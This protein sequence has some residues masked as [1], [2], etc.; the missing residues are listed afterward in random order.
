MTQ[1]LERT[2]TEAATPLG[3]VAP[4]PNNDEWLEDGRAGDAPP[5]LSRLANL[6]RRGDPACLEAILGRRHAAFDAGRRSLRARELLGGREPPAPVDSRLEGMTHFDEELDESQRDA[7]ARALAA[8]DLCLIQGLPGTGKTRVLSEIAAQWARRDGRV[9]VVAPR[10]G[11]LAPILNPLTLRD[12]VFAVWL[13]APGEVG[14]APLP[15]LTDAEQHRRFEQQLRQRCEQALAEAEDRYRQAERDL[16]LLPP[17]EEAAV[18]WQKAAQERQDLQARRQA[19]AEQVRGE[20]DKPPANDGDFLKAVRGERARHDEC[21]RTL[22]QQLQEAAKQLEQVRAEQVQRLQRVERQR[23]LMEAR[24]TGRWFTLAWWRAVLQGRRANDRLLELQRLEA[25]ALQARLVAE[26]HA[27]ELQAQR[28][29]EA[30][31]HAR[32]LA[33]LL[34]TETARRQQAVDRELERVATTA[35]QHLQVWRQHYSALA[36]PDS[37]DELPEAQRVAGLRK[38]LELQFQRAHEQRELARRRQAWQLALPSRLPAELPKLANVVA[39]S[40]RAWRVNPA[41]AGKFDVVLVDN[42]DALSEQDLACLVEHADRAVL[43]GRPPVGASS[44]PFHRLWQ[45]L[46]CDPRTLPHQWEQSGDS[47]VCRLHAVADS[48]TEHVEVEHLV[49]EPDVQLRI[50]SRPGGR[51]VLA[52][53]AFPLARFGIHEAKAFLYRNL[54]ELPLRPGT[55]WLRW[56]ENGEWLLADFTPPSGRAEEEMEVSLE[57][58]VSEVVHSAAVN[59]RKPPAAC[60]MTARLQFDRRLGWDLTRAQQWL[61]DRTGL[62]DLGRTCWLQY[63]WRARP[64]L[65]GFWHEHLYAAAPIMGT[66]GTAIS[67]GSPSRAGEACVRFVCVGGTEGKRHPPPSRGGGARP[68][69]RHGLEL[70]LS[71]PRQRQQLPADLRGALPTHGFVN[72]AEGRTLLEQLR[73]LLNEPTGRADRNVYPTVAVVSWQASQVELLRLLWERECRPAETAAGTPVCFCPVE[74]LAD[75]A[76][77]QPEVVC[78]SLCRSHAQRPL[79]Y[80]ECVDEWVALLT[81]AAQRLILVGD[82]DSLERRSQCL[83]PLGKQDQATADFER[84]LT[85]ALLCLARSDATDKNVHPT[86]KNAAR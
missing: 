23:R 77:G 68:N 56:K 82:P 53:V 39:A 6:L 30:D 86:E 62:Q 10:P 64:D 47:L 46:H 2:A 36:H 8:P 25:E 66:P 67:P 43:A 1:A 29:Q 76:T 40:V 26:E 5:P 21:C 24:A 37:P 16:R 55:A 50:L 19:L 38:T 22:D 52:E 59:G 11:S 28:A 32:A 18:L 63:Q 81:S 70:D 84:R 73:Q 57:A 41:P 33:H 54:Q 9:L 31:Y 49:D 34:D 14:E 79:A 69:P 7:V 71:N 15:Q 61:R 60:W 72:L 58:G 83:K 35:D 13:P 75:W 85:A 3:G 20:L 27:Q 74:K 45:Q 44:A 12:F 42:A 65:A 48:E 17:L 80:A 51:P 4:R 78:A